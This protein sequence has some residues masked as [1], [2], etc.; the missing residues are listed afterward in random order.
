MEFL[1]VPRPVECDIMLLI[2]GES[3]PIFLDWRKAYTAARFVAGIS[4][5]ADREGACECETLVANSI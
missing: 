4:D 5:I 1:F 2:E 3:D